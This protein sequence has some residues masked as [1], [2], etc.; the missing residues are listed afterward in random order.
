MVGKLVFVFFFEE[1]YFFHEC[2]KILCTVGQCLKAQT[3]MMLARKDSTIG[4]H[5]SSSILEYLLILDVI[6]I[7]NNIYCQ[8]VISYINHI[9]PLKNMF[10]IKGNICL[11][12]LH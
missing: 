4:Y 3:L 9:K 7:D 8:L 12:N 6:S 11:G 1:K 5:I 2:G 10:R